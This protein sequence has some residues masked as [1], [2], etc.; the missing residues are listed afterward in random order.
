MFYQTYQLYMGG[1]EVTRGRREKGEQTGW[2]GWNRLP[3]HSVNA[4]LLET[5]KNDKYRFDEYWFYP[6]Y[7]YQLDLPCRI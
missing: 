1:R 7:F 4:V 6:N 2:P 5:S 3:E